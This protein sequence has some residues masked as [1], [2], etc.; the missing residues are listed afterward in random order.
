MNKP[1]LL[2]TAILLTC[3]A[4]NGQG[5]AQTYDAN[6]AFIANELGVNETNSSFGPFSVGYGLNFGD[7]TAFG[8]AEHDNAFHCR[9]DAGCPRTQHR[10]APRFYM[11]RIDAAPPSLRVKP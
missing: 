9:H 8:A 4:M 5:V 6:A 10:G 2:T 3:W 1:L 11:C 7:F